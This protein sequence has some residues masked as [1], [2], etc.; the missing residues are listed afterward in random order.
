MAKFLKATE[1][2]FEEAPLFFITS[3][4]KMEGREELTVFIQG[5]VEEFYNGH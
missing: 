4:E 5:N 3:A 1:E 2:I